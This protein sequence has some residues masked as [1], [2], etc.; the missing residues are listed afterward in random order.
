MCH[1]ERLVD[2]CTNTEVVSVDT[3]AEYVMKVITMMKMTTEED[4]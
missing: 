4:F 1:C 2:C 3:D